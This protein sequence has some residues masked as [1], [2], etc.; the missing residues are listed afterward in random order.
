MLNQRIQLN[1]LNVCFSDRIVVWRAAY[2]RL[3][4]YRTSQFHY[5]T[6]IKSVNIKHM[7]KIEQGG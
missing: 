1:E 5:K 7:K 4:C 6:K 3:Q 2:A